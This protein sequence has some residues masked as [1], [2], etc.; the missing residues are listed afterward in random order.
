MDGLLM[1]YFILKPRGN[2]IYAKASRQAML[3]YAEVIEP[4]NQILKIP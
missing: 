4:I 1:K 3:E 2:N